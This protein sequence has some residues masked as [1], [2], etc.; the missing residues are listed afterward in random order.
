MA[1]AL[2]GALV[3]SRRHPG[4]IL[5]GVRVCGC[6]GVW[7][8]HL[9][10]TRRDVAIE[11]R[12][13][14]L[15]SSPSGFVARGC[16]VPR[17]HPIDERNGNGHVHQQL[18]CIPRP[19]HPRPHGT[20]GY[21]AYTFS[22]KCACFL[23]RGTHSN[24]SNGSNCSNGSNGSNGDSNS[25]ALA[26]P[27]PRAPNGLGAPSHPLPRCPIAPHAHSQYFSRALTEA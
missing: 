23:S 4:K 13:E 27:L 3:G 21:P 20:R 6:A 2:V 1:T 26:F 7:V 24:D 10:A 19:L 17:V 22:C 5:S 12:I 9:C 11:V 14:A 8:R 18:R 16:H 15:T 25:S